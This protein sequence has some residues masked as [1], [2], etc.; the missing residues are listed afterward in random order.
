MLVAPHNGCSPTVLRGPHNTEKQAG[1][2]TA[3][4]YTLLV[5]LSPGTFHLTPQRLTQGNIASKALPAILSFPAKYIAEPFFKFQHTCRIRHYLAFQNKEIRAGGEFV[6]LED[7]LR[8]KSRLSVRFPTFTCSIWNMG[9]P[10][11]SFKTLLSLSISA[12]LVALRNFI[13]WYSNS[14]EY[15]LKNRNKYLLNIIQQ[16]SAGKQLQFL[17]FKSK[18][19]RA[20]DWYIKPNKNTLGLHSNGTPPHQEILESRESIEPW[21]VWAPSQSGHHTTRVC[22]A[23]VTFKINSIQSFFDHTI[24]LSPKS[25]VSI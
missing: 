21:L 11:S 16:E 24:S 4:A 6:G 18:E 19:S 2:C 22:A 10:H 17:D 20:S 23:L 9:Y 15:Q 3:S 14:P 1:L 5:H 7:R 8:K 12:L 13:Y 25:P